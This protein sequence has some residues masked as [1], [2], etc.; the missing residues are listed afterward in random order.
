MSDEEIREQAEFRRSL[1][2]FLDKLLTPEMR[3]KH[4]DPNEYG[5]GWSAE[6]RREFAKILGKEGFLGRAWP[7]EYG[8]RGLG[9]VYDA[10]LFDEIEYH[11]APFMEPSVC[12]VP[13][14]LLRYGTEEQKARFLP[15]LLREGLSVFVGYSEPEAGSDL[16]N[17]STV[18]QPVDGGYVVNGAKYYST[19][20]G[21]ADFGLCAVRTQPRGDRKYDGISLLLV[22]MDAPGVELQQHRMMTG[23]A[24]HAVYF[25]DVFVEADML[26]GAEGRGWP[27]LMAAINYER[28]VIAAS[29]QG[30]SLLE[31][32]REHVLAAPDPVA[33]DR[34][35]SAAVE[36]RAASLYT[37]EVVRHAGTLEEDPGDGAT[38]AQLLK[39]EAV[40][41]IESMTLQLLGAAS[42][43]QSGD[44]AVAG[45]RF[46]KMF[47]GDGMMEF[48]AGG[49]DITRQV[50]SRRILQMG[51]GSK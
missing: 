33:A 29:G 13:F 5:G 20:A 16:A 15:R 17:L 35:V 49:F 7:V 19:F 10:I 38:V 45:G 37:D 32:L 3:A 36:A 1:S 34:L 14:T 24:H 22:P 30:D 27:A 2:A 21:T 12:Y 51:R 9:M 48:A 31:H 4:Y 50:I 44:Q 11:E 26:V 39:R 42:T 8:G 40:R 47:I 28:L 43:V 6:F 23:E 25:T 46:A 18:A 41:S